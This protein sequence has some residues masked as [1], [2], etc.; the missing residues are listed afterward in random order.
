MTNTLQRHIE[1]SG[2]KFRSN[3]VLKSKANN[4]A[5]QTPKSKGNNTQRYTFVANKENSGDLINPVTSSAKKPL[6]SKGKLF[7]PI[8]LILSLELIYLLI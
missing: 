3:S 1:T 8:M 7:T 6:G 4:L 5:A 2:S